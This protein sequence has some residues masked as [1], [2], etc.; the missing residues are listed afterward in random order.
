MKTMLRTIAILAAALAIVGLTIAFSNT[1]F[2]QSL[3]MR[4][5][6]EAG[7]ERFE[8]AQDD[9]EAQRDG[10]R[11]EG[12]GE[13]EDYRP[14][15]GGVTEVVKSLIKIAAVVVLVVLGGW[16]LGRGRRDR[17]RPP[18]AESGSPPPA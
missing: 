18:R 1:T 14:H 11:P 10:E 16:I 2:G 12:L 4:G 17:P 3:R 13:R 8:Q 5:G 6:E 7:R 9:V 15:L